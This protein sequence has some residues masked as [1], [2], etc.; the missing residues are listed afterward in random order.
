M[1]TIFML[2][3]ESRLMAVYM[4]VSA[5]NRPPPYFL[6][7]VQLSCFVVSDNSCPFIRITFRA[8]FYEVEKS[9]FGSP[10]HPVI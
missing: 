3:C 10:S 5:K 6:H 7:S 2:R 9:G 1:L 8:G 4:K